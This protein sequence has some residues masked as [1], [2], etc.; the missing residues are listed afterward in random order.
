MKSALILLAGG[1]G[2]R[3]NSNTPKQ[4]VEVNN[5]AIFIYSILPFLSFVKYIVIVVHNDYVNFAKKAIEKA[6]IPKK[7]FFARGGNTGLN[8][9]KNGFNELVINNLSVDY[10]FIHDAAR[11]F[12]DKETILPCVGVAKN[13]KYS[14][15]ASE[16]VESVFD[17]NNNVIKKDGL[18]KIMSPHCFEISFLK[19]LLEQNKFSNELTVFN[20]MMSQKYPV[21]LSKTTEKNFKITSQ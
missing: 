10:V 5:T 19:G 15:S 6:N 1:T 14:F 9:A 12:V 3:A 21:V 13:N 17:S 11:P 18:F 8:S 4:F 20:L 7:V 2:T 16:L